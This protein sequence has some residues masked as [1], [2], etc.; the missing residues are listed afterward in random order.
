MQNA[1][2]A[3]GNTVAIT[4]ASSPPAGVQAG[5]RSTFAAFSG[6][7]RI[8]NTGS[9][10]VHLGVGSNAAAAQSA[11]AAAVSSTPAAGIPL[12]PG[13]TEVFSFEIDSF[14]S[15]LA[16]NNTTVYITPGAGI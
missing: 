4:A 3:L 14:F 10:I 12:L 11:A 5:T 16:A 13:A 7:Y 15:G 9:V 1:F 8:I 2:K 6:Q